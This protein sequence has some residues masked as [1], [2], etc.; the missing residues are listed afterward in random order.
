VRITVANVKGGVGKTTAAVLLASGLARRG[1]TVLIDADP[2]S[3]ALRWSDQAG[4]LVFPVIAWPVRDLARRV[5]QIV[6]DYEH[7]VIDT[8]PEQEHLVRQALLVTDRLLVPLA[9]TRIEVDRLAATLMLA[10]EA[11]DVG[12]R[13]DVRLLLTRVRPRTRSASLLRARLTDLDLPVLAA[14]VRLL[15]CYAQAHGQPLPA[16]L[17]DYQQVLGEL[18]ELDRADPR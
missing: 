10:E 2:K 14:E 6:G 17:G 12:A 4:D 3:S 8:G 9:P 7:V 5:S 11:E 1:R 15:E 16:D 18:F 13:L